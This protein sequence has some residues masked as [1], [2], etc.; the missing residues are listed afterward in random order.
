[1][2]RAISAGLFL[3][4][5]VAAAMA[6]INAVI[7]A[8][9]KSSSALLVANAAASDRLRT[10]IEIVFA[11]GNTTSN[12]IIFWVKSVG[13]ETIPAIKESDVFLTTPT[14]VGR[15]PHWDGTG[16]A[17]PDYWDYVIENGTKWSQ[18]ITVK[19]TLHMVTAGVS[20]GIHELRMAVHNGV[21]AEKEFSI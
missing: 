15:I 11:S 10:D 5:G 7:P 9:G 8:V 20:A 18:A 17:P 2:E 12:E 16:G 14:T 4:A 21:N 1:M 3:I 13:S 19:V 6:L